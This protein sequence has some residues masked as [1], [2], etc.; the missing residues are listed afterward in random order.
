MPRYF[1]HLRNDNGEAEDETGQ[2][3]PDLEAA[4]RRALKAAGEIIA[5]ELAQGRDRV[6][7]A[8][9]IEDEGGRRMLTLPLRSFRSRRKATADPRRSVLPAEAR[10]EPVDAAGIITWIK[11]RVIVRLA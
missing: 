10:P 3:L 8:I 5:E 2:E 7:I 11:R 9:D 4:R 1:F 6:R